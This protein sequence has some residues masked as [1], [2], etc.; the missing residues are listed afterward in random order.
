VS[1]PQ[2]HLNKKKRRIQDD[3]I[4]D[5]IQGMN[6]EPMDFRDDMPVD[7]MQVSL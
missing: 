3:Q 4:R 6:D 5:D 7:N 1:K 2:Q